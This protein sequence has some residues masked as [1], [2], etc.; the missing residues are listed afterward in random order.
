[1]LHRHPRDVPG[2]GPDLVLPDADRLP[3]RHRP[4]EVP[5]RAL[6]QPD[7]LPDPDVPEAHLRRRHPAARAGR[8]VRSVRGRD[9][10][11][12][13]DLFVAAG[14]PVRVPVMTGAVRL[15]NVAV[16]YRIPRERIGSLKE[17]A[18]RRI[19]RRVGYDEFEALRDVSFE[20]R[21]G[22]VVGVIGRN[23]AGK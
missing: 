22:E 17:Y 21:P 11:D 13:L 14:G 7:V 2:P 1:A 15:E 18:I 8:G 4:A 6:G 12:R 9:F 23:G 19:K 10:R 16:R 20:V 3:P 5:L